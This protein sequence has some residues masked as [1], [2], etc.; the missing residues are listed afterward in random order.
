MKD[1]EFINKLIEK[2]TVKKKH[3]DELQRKYK[4]EK[5]KLTVVAEEIKQRIIAKKEKVKRYQNRINQFHQN[6]TF[7]NNQGKF[8][9]NL[10]GETQQ[11]DVP[12][13]DEAKEFWKGVWENEKKH[14]E[15]A[16][17]LENVRKSF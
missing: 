11:S 14:A 4:I 2:K 1:L 3:R 17:W 9:K 16:E 12:D 5:R 7:Q 13:A 6:R 10:N 15:D 8:Y